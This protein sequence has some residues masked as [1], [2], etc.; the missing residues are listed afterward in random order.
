MTERTVDRQ[1]AAA[2]TD[3]LR[4]EGGLRL[5]THRLIVV[6]SGGGSVDLELAVPDSVRVDHPSTE[7]HVPF[8]IDR[9]RVR[10]DSDGEIAIT[11]RSPSH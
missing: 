7:G 9:Y 1:F 2:D 10:I 4:V 6:G 5:S 11:P 3:R 8:D